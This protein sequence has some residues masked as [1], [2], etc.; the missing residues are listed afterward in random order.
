MKIPKLLLLFILTLTIS[1]SQNNTFK[2]GFTGAYPNYYDTST[3]NINWSYYGEL[4][5]NTIQ[6]W[7][8]GDNPFGL[9]TLG[10]LNQSGINLDSY[11]QP[12]T[13][14][15]VGYGRQQINY[16]VSSMDS[17]FNFNRVSSC[18]AQYNE[19]GGHYVLYFDKNSSCNNQ[20]NPGGLALWQVKENGFQSFSGVPYDPMNQ[21]PF[22]GGGGAINNYYVKPRMRID[23]SVAFGTTQNVCKVIIIAYNGDTVRSVIITTEDFKYADYN[24]RYIEDYRIH[25]D[26][27][28]VSA[29]TITGINKGRPSYDP[30]YLDS[31]KVDYQIYWYGTVSFWIDYVKVMDESANRLFGNV[32]LKYLLK[33]YI[34]RLKSNDKENNIKGLFL[35]EIDYSNL[36]CLNRLNS[37]LQEWT[38][39]DKN[40][41][42]T[43]LIKPETFFA[44][45]K[46]PVNM[47]AIGR[48]N[49]LVLN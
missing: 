34:Q 43:A 17:R 36:M 46:N 25:G 6:G 47:P 33:N 9:E 28:T 8:I 39:N 37:L 44:Y 35:G 4:N 40:Y 30:A 21:T 26:L 38:D 12:D 22:P 14:R 27:L 41:Y 19:G 29:D 32:F 10:K 24:G 23:S 49:V 13:L 7:W 45:I 42:L 31:C 3:R 1:Y 5:L 11:F 2:L 20:Q 15:Q 48:E 18:G 16:A